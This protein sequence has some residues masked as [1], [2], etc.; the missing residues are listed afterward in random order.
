MLANIFFIALNII[1]NILIKMLAPDIMIEG[2]NLTLPAL[3]ITLTTSLLL[4]GYAILIARGIKKVV[5]HYF[6]KD[7]ISDIVKILIA[8]VVVYIVFNLF[9]PAFTHG[10]LTFIIPLC[11]CAVV[12]GGMLVA[13]GMLKRLARNVNKK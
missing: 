8:A 7:L 5:G 11:T 13:M 2:L 12:Y 10:Y 9:A 3:L 1:A 6:T 4:I